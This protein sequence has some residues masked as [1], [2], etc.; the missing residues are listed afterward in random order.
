MALAPALAGLLTAGVSAAVTRSE[1]AVGTADFGAA[2]RS[3]APSELTSRSV[4]PP[5]G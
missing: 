5:W 1:D 3:G 4:S 2:P